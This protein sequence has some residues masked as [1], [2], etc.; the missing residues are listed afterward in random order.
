MFFQAGG[1]LLQ[2][3]PDLIDVGR[4]TAGRE[5]IEKCLKVAQDLCHQV[6]FPAEPVECRGELRDLFPEVS[7]HAVFARV[8]NMQRI[9]EGKAMAGQLLSQARYRSSGGGRYGLGGEKLV[10]L[11]ADRGEVVAELVVDA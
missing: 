1:P 8:M 2:L 9:A 7:E 5:I 10:D 6:V 4:A 3:G 11:A